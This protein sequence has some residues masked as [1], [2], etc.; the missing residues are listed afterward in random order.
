MQL[1]VARLCLDCEELHADKRC[2]RCASASYAFLTQWVPCEERRRHKRTRAPGRSTRR[3]RATVR[4]LAHWFRGDVDVS[5]SPATR[6]SDFVSQ[7][8][9]KLDE[10]GD[11]PGVEEIQARRRKTIAV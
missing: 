9:S 7:Q 8:L 1:R 10:S 6:R 11:S 5:P 2:P 3:F 4:S